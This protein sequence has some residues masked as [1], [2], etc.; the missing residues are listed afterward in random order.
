MSKRIPESVIES[1]I[2]MYLA[3]DTSV[4]DICKLHDISKNKMYVEI[5]KRGIKLEHRKRIGL[6]ENDG[7]KRIIT[8]EQKVEISRLH[9]M[10]V[11]YQAIADMCD[12]SYA[13]AVKYRDFVKQREAVSKATITRRHKLSLWTRFKR[14][15]LS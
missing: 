11:S 5:N 13:S 7:R 8:T 1:A 9:H 2:K 4:E 15:L 3:N 10:G 6:M 14:W 12:V